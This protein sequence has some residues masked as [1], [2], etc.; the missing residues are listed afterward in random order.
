[1]AIEPEANK[2]NYLDLFSIE[3]NSLEAVP[4]LLRVWTTVSLTIG[5]IVFSLVVLIAAVL[6][7]RLGIKALFSVDDSFQEA[8]KNFLFAL[9][10]AFGAPFLVWRTW[11]AHVQANAATTQATT[12]QE[13]HLTGIFTKSVELLGLV[14][15]IKTLTADG[16]PV[17]R[18]LPNLEARLGAL[19]SLERLL[20]ESNKDQ[21]AI[22]ETLCA[23]IRE[24]SPLKIPEDEN[25]R[26]S[27]SSGKNAPEPSRRTDVQ[28]AITIIGRRSTVI[29]DIGR[30]E[31][32]RLDLRE[33][34]LVGYDF[35][36]LNFDA[37]D[38]SGSFLN[39]CKLNGASFQSS[40]FTNTLFCGAELNRA[41]LALSSFNHCNFKS[42]KI[43]DADFSQT[44]IEDTDL[45]E[46]H[47]EN[48]DI[49]GANL[50]NAF[51]SWLELM[52]AD[53][54]KNGATS[55]NANDIV[56]TNEL[57]RKSRRD[58]MTV[59]SQASIDAINLMK[60]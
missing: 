25:E 40:L 28:A 46:A 1:M 12:A 23:Y 43:K 20:R 45:R 37:S 59:L 5:L 48:L 21:Q 53:A 10:G 15:E 11:V 6:L 42:A 58:E 13:S 50:A 29:H 16:S 38:F 26:D 49:R 19:Y 35:S 22:L 32:W 57:F 34:N 54:I 8:A 47:V 2:R 7:F 17:A 60:S 30:R 44:T 3:R 51:S 56:R 36:S 27:I 52:V 14:R 4:K 24:N 33:T 9:A 39:F 31:G 55:F 18:S 41:S